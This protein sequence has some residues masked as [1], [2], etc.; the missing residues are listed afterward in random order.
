ML[1]AAHLQRDLNIDPFRRLDRAHDSG[2]ERRS[3]EHLGRLA[4]GCIEGEEWLRWRVPRYP[5]L[6]LRGRPSARDEA[7]EAAVHAVP[8]EWRR[9][10]CRLVLMAT[11]P[12]G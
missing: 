5:R 12:L 6:D 9:R 11:R 1:Y 7:G 3:Q 10:S 4:K 2:A 8:L